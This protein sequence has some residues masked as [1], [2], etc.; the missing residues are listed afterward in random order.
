MAT[1]MVTKDDVIRAL[2]ELPAESLVEVRRF[3]DF[4]RF[5]AQSRPRKLVKLGGLWKDWPPITD[6]DIAQ[7]RR[8]M[9]GSFGE[10]E[11]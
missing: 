10:R 1:E 7:A 5:K 3:V 6:E 8:E 11:L 2:D 9:W 4:M